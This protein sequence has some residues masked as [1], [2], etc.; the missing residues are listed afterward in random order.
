MKFVLTCQHAVYN[1]FTGQTTSYEGDKLTSEF[2]AEDLDSILEN[3]ELFLKGCGFNFDGK[4]VIFNDEETTSCG[5]NC[6]SCKCKPDVDM[7]GRC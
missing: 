3:L 4:L 7:D 1:T 6:T 5:G 2:K